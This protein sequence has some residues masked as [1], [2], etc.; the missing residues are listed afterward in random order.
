MG[1]LDAVVGGGVGA[2]RFD[3]AVVRGAPTCRFD[4]PFATGSIDWFGAPVALG[5]VPAAQYAGRMYTAKYS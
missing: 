2:V 4:A 3:A 5:S 1:W